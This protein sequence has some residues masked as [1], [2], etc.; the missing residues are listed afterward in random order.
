[1]RNARAPGKSIMSVPRKMP[2]VSAKMRRPSI[3]LEVPSIGKARKKRARNITG[4]RKKM[5][6]KGL[7]VAGLR[8][9]RICVR[10]QRKPEQKEAVMTR[11]K[12]RALKAVSPATIIITPTDMRVMIPR[13]RQE[14]FSRRKMKA[15][16]ST[17]ASTEDLH[18]VKKV[19]LMKRREKFPRPMSR[20]VAVPQG[21]MRVR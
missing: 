3:R 9:R 15:K 4:V 1:M 14:G 20:A 7:L 8:R 6:L 18:I 10:D 17:K 21:P 16:R 5:L 2:F 12:P 11:M 13:R 19:R